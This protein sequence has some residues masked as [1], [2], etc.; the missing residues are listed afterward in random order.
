MVASFV[1][2]LPIG[3]NQAIGKGMNRIVDA[4]IGGWELGGI[5]TAQS[6]APMGVTQS[7]SNLWAGNQ[8]PNLIG[9]PSVP[10]DVRNKLNGYF[11]PAAFG[12]VNPDIIGSSPRFLSSYIGPPLW[13]ED[14][15]LM[16]NYHITER[17]YVQLRLEAYALKNAPQ[18]GNPNISFGSTSF[19]QITSASG[20]RSLQVAAKFYY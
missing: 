5:I 19:G 6:G 20:Q 3:R 8:R 18:W 4:V 10:G 2:Q 1:Y 17:K 7:A 14:A 15:T 11:N 13:N 9:D 12:S 16:K